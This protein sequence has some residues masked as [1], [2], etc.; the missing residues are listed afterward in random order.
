MERENREIFRVA[1]QF[2]MEGMPESIMAYG[3]GH[4]ND[5]CLVTCRVEEEY[6]K[7]ILQRINHEIFKKPWELMENVVKVTEFL[8][9]KIPGGRRCV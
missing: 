1:E 2:E 9:K 7:Y 6:K 3:N 8:R 4:I 5:T